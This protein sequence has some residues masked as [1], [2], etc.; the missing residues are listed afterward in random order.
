MLDILKVPSENLLK[1]IKDE[2]K[3]KVDLNKEQ[4]KNYVLRNTKKYKCI[5]E[6]EFEEEILF[7]IKHSV[8][9]KFITKYFGINDDYVKDIAKK[10]KCQSYLLSSF[11]ENM[12]A[13]CF[14]RNQILRACEEFNYICPMCFK[15]LDITNLKSLTGHHIQ[16]FARGGK[17]IKDN[18]LP[19]HVS[20]HFEDFKLLHSALFDSTDPIYSARYFNFLKQKLRSEESGITAI[21]KKTKDRNTA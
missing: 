15:P 2:Q 13:R 18:C 17:T 20:C 10:H 1:Y 6:Y 14:S 19:L 11:T 12:D 7:M 4:I 3:V 8:S 21:L 16:P 5:Y 9:L